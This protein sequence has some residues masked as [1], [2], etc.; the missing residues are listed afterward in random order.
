MPHQLVF[1]E[2]HYVPAARTLVVAGRRRRNIEHPLLGKLLIGLGMWLFGDNSLGWRALSTV[3]AAGVV[4]GIFWILWWTF[5][6]LRTATFGAALVILNM[7][8]FIQARIAMLDGFMAAFVI[9]ALAMLAWA[10]RRGGWWRWL[11]GAVLM[12]LAVGD[13]VDRGSLCRVRRSSPFC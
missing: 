2:T 6:R 4:F 10:M 9:D 13:E 8:V 12:G 7:T 11:A 1:D 3:A 5:G